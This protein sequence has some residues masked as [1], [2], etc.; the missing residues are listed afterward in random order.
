[1]CDLLSQC[2]LLI[3][4]KRKEFSTRLL[5]PVITNKAQTFSRVVSLLWAFAALAQA[6]KIQPTIAAFRINH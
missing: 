4:R 6:R 1:L 5:G 2:R 3:R